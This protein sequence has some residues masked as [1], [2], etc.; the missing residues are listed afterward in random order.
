M[1]ELDGVRELVVVRLAEVVAELREVE[2]RLSD[3]REGWLRPATW[4]SARASPPPWPA[5]SWT[6]R[7]S[8]RAAWW[9]PAS[10]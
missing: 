9:P 4:W 1:A 10:G 5:P 8:R 7:C 2:T 3:L 6:C